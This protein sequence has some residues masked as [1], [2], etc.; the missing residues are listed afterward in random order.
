MSC[1]RLIKGWMALDY[2]YLIQPRLESRN[3]IGKSGWISRIQVLKMAWTV[4]RL[5]TKVHQCHVTGQ[6]VTSVII[7]MVEH[8]PGL[9][10]G[11]TVEELACRQMEL[12]I[13]EHSGRH[14]GRTC[15]FSSLARHKW[16]ADM[17]TTQDFLTST[18]SITLQHSRAHHST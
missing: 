10:S 8:T 1:I 9:K 2:W 15:D 11:P 18:K 3:P 7:W 12:P 13:W 17:I 6:V 4:Q 16:P 14:A 5:E